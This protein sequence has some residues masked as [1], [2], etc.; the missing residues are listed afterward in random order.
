MIN[1]LVYL[2]FSGKGR[3]KLTCLIQTL[4]PLNFFYRVFRVIVIGL[5]NSS[6][7]LLIGCGGQRKDVIGL[8]YSKKK[9]Q[10]G[11]YR[12]M[13]TIFIRSANLE[14]QLFWWKVSHF[15][16][17]S[18]L[19]GHYHQTCQCAVLHGFVF[20]LLCSHLHYPESN[21]LIFGTQT[22]QSFPANQIPPQSPT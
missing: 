9:K 15:V 12:K 4:I 19:L 20:L 21:W 7:S 18:V 16:F 8:A 22:K 14:D 10:H 17:Y 13:Q 1:L 3:P 5:A 11:R 2:R 6:Y